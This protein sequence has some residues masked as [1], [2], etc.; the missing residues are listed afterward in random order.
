[1]RDTGPVANGGTGILTAST[2]GEATPES[3][4]R[5]WPQ[6]LL[7]GLAMIAVAVVA[8]AWNAAG[9]R[10]LLGALGLFLAARG[11][12]LLR[13][14]R[15]GGLAADLTA[16][17]RMLGGGAA[18]VGVAALAGAL[19]SAVLAARVLLVAVPVTLVAG[20]VVLLVRGGSARRGGQALLVWSVLV[21]GLLVVTGVVQGWGRATDVAMV[22]TA[23]AVA[24]LGV[25]LLIGAAQLRAVAAQ[26]ARAPAP[27]AC[28]G[29]ACGAG[30]CGAL[31]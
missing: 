14:A 26:P 8:V 13:S 18:V 4:R 30:G 1:V 25:P 16:R 31:D 29:C 21:A 6:W 24:V 7:L 9:A 19:A 17:A 3:A 23:L 20:A 11:V 2:L 5:T 15:S 28:A 27:A 12:A 10:L 22:V